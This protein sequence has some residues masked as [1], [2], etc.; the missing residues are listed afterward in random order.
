MNKCEVR[1]LELTDEI[2][3]K[4]KNN[5]SQL[6]RITDINRVS[7]KEE[8]LNP[9]KVGKHQRDSEYLG[10][11]GRVEKS[12]VAVRKVELLRLRETTGNNTEEGPASTI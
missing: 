2:V 12:V 11:A 1:H 8:T 3:G 4:G 9:A 6:V 5:I 10:S 7:L